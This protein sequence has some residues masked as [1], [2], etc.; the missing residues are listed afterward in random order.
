[1]AVRGGEKGQDLMVATGFIDYFEIRHL[2]LPTHVSA[3]V[4]L[5][6]QKALLPF[7]EV[8]VTRQLTIALI[9]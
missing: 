7:R 5:S 4:Y 1:M 8:F 9:G 3:V 2:L 6:Q